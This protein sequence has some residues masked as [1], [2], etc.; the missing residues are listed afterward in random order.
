MR[1]SV[2]TRVYLTEKNLEVFIQLVHTV[3][4]CRTRIDVDL[5]VGGV[6]PRLTHAIT[7]MMTFAI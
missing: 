1:L 3:M 7:I 2:N 5:S 6:S 4:T